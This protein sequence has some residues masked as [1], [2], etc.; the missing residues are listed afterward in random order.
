MAEESRLPPVV[1]LHGCGGSPEQTF[2]ASGWPQAFTA[3]GREVFAPRLPGHGHDSVSHDPV[4]Y[5]DLAAALLPR[6]PQGPVD[7][8][9]F[10]L[11]AKIALDL[12]VRWPAR[13]RRMVLGGIGDNA[14]APETVGETAASA[15]E[16]GAGPDTPPGVRAFLA[17]WDPA[18]NDPLAV[19]AILRRPP[20]P[21]L[22]EAGVRAIRCPAAVVNGADDFV[23]TMGTRLFAA[24]GAE[25]LVLPG[26]GHFDLPRQPQFRDAA[27]RFLGVT[28]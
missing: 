16:H 4:D 6:L 15:L 9:G 1:L 22:D 7:L 3:S 14:F 25:P 13:V 8:V 10:S 5:A 2:L 11:G 21:L 24:L 28:G 17:T 18:L 27:V 19:A 20:N 23:M 12:A 26:V